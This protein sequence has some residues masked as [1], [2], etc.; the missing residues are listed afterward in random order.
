M[1]RKVPF[2][3]AFTVPFALQILGIVGLVGYLSYRSGEKAVQ[4]LAH[5]LMAKTEALVVQR[6]DQYL[7]FP[8]RI[9]QLNIAEVNSG[10][11]RAND[12]DQLHRHLIQQHQ[13][14]PEVTSVHFG[15]QQGDFLV[16]HRVSAS[17]IEAGITKI[18]P[19]EE[20]AVEVG[21]SDPD[22]PSRLNLY[23]LNQEGEMGRYLET[24]EN[25]DV[26]SRPWYRQ[27]V[28][29]QK[30]GWTQAFQIGTTNVLTINAYAPFYNPSQELEGVFSVNVSLERLNQFLA[31]LPI[32][33][34]G[35]V[36]IIERNG[37]LIA[38]S[39]GESPYLIFSLSSS[40]IPQPG[41][42]EFHRKSVRE[43]SNFLIKGAA[44][45]LEQDFVDLG[46][47]A[48]SQQIEVKIETPSG[49]KETYCLR[50]LPYQDDY[51]FDWLVVTVV[52]KSEF[53]GEFRTSIYRTMVWCGVALLGSLGLAW[54]TSRRIT[55]S[56]LR[57][58]QA[59]KSVAQG[60]FN[61][62]FP[63]SRIREVDTLS[64]SFSQMAQS[65]QEAEKLRDNYEARLEQEVEEKTI[66]LQESQAELQ[67]ITDSISGCI[68]FTDA[69]MRY[70]F[71]NKTYE[72]WF[73]CRKE[74]ILGRTVEEVIGAEAY[75][76]ALPDIKR[77]LA[78]E[79]VTYEKQLPYQGGKT[80]YVSAVLTPKWDG[81]NHVLGYYALIT[82]ISD[83][84]Q[85]ELE[86]KK[87]NQEL[88]ELAKVDGLTQVANRRAFD[89]RLQ[90]EWNRA[91]RQSLPLSLLFC[92][93]DYF[94][95]YNDYYGHQEGDY[96]LQKVAL[97]IQEN[98]QRAE[99][100]PARY[101]GEE[102]AIICAGINAEKAEA[103]AKKI[104]Q[105]LFRSGIPH[106][107][108]PSTKWV[109]LSIGVASIIPRESDELEDLLTQADR[110]LYLAKEQGRD[111][112]IS[113]QL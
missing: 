63:T 58:S 28:E 71:V 25:I 73:N 42:I 49:K 51:G 24:L 75:Q 64:E 102:F 18:N 89:E 43:S 11:V 79:T 76:K 101:G 9:N 74:E 16:V 17:Q 61:H 70:R 21:R 103:L 98:C 91:R 99:D 33:E 60:K 5:Q 26:R 47:I 29:T 4:D 100:F 15:N 46:A 6:L 88:E 90:Q 50:V 20:L 59:S 1:S 72:A 31:N 66:T 56:L 38:N 23:A 107:N 35:Q 93:V 48:S 54:W 110:A 84:K 113:F 53:I 3:L 77:V 55:R 67:L 80:R 30:S 37:L 34:R 7:K 108:N 45:A 96:C 32:S 8:Q 86:L 2:Y 95:Q 10:A 65:L 39:I 22:D 92:D 27:A 104:Q 44:A 57:L 13:Q 112:V 12:L 111:R 97:M 62:S 68:S 81:N 69:S 94:K 36:F 87:V 78:G 40:S 106:K 52:P 109:T 82:D 14:F 19:S 105:R 41:E 85:L 83:R